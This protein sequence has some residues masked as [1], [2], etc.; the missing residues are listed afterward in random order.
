MKNFKLTLLI[1]L[2][3][4]LNMFG[5][6]NSTNKLRLTQEAIEKDKIHSLFEYSLDDDN[7]VTFE[8]EVPVERYVKSLKKAQGSKKFEILYSGKFLNQ[9][10]AKKLATA[11]NSSNDLSLQKA[12][13]NLD[14]SEKSI[15]FGYNL[16]N[17]AGDPLKQLKYLFS[18]GT[19]IV[20]SNSFGTIATGGDLEENNIGLNLRFSYVNNG[21]I[22][23]L[24]SKRN[25]DYLTQKEKI[26]INRE[27]LLANYNNK[28]IE[29]NKKDLPKIIEQNK[30]IYKEDEAIKN[31]KTEL[32]KKSDEL[33]Y[34]MINE[35]IEYVE[36]NKLF[37]SIYNSWFTFES[38]IPLGDVEYD[39]TPIT[40]DNK[41]S[42]AQYYGFNTNLSFN[43]Y[44]QKTNWF[45]YF[46]KLIGTVKGNSSINVDGLSAKEFQ[47]L[48]TL[49][50]VTTLTAPV[51]AIDV[52]GDYSRFITSSL[53]IEAAFFV[54]NTIGISPAIEKNFGKYDA[55]N[56]KIGIPFSVKDKKGEP[57]VN[58][59]LQW[60]ETKTLNKS[61]H[62][63]GFSTSFFF[64]DLIK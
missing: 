4:C 17:R 18:I 28:I 42:H 3:V 56:W 37:T 41:A 9:L 38:Y 50:D 14:A 26:K 11:F 20:A 61:E 19:K 64:G 2:I 1:C 46:G 35:E 49:N 16:D 60:K 6:V 5:Q 21:R 24:I 54:N 52:Q 57:T 40:S 62:L 43:W 55:V 45:S 33:L 51:K 23:W 48:V 44:K 47:S 58:F 7:K 31:I 36:G 15:S 27:F 63:I 13:F 39:I 12:F 29:F 59:E 22:G 10:F 34:E 25:K 30:A 32:K 53:K 8:V